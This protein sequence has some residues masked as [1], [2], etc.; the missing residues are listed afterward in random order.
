MASLVRNTMVLYEN[1]RDFRNLFAAQP[2]FCLP[3]YSMLV[4][5]ADKNLSKKY[6]T[7]CK[8]DAT[9]ITKN[10]IAALHHDVKHFCDMYDYRNNTPD[11]DWGNSKDSLE[12]STL[13]LTTRDP[14]EK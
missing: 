10:A 2:E 12:R 8:T 6:R 5:A 3:H 14:E 7:Q 11:A 4:E 1:D 9:Q 13:F